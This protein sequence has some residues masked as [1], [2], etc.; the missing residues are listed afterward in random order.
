MYHFY[1]V[2]HGHLLSTNDYNM[3]CKHVSQT[4]YPHPN[5]SKMFKDL[6]EKKR[7]VYAT[8]T[9]EVVDDTPEQ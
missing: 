9:L 6:K 8:G 1:H 4:H 2:S 3:L 5:L 7:F